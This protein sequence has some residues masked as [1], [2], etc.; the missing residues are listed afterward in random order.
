VTSLYEIKKLEVTDTPVLLFECTLSSGAVERWSTHAVTVDAQSY[1][2]RILRHNLFEI[3]GTGEDGIDSISRVAV[4]LA[5]ADS[6]FSQ[7]ERTVGFKGA[8]VIVRFL[9]Y[10][11]KTGAA[12]SDQRV[13]FR[14]TCNP[15]DEI[16]ES[17]LRLTFMSR[18][19][20]QRTLLPQ[21]RIQRR[22][23]WVFPTTADQRR[24]GIDGLTKGK[25]SPFFRCGYSP[26]IT[27][28]TGNSDT[29]GPFTS[30]D[31]T[32][33]QCEQRGMFSSDSA[34]RITRRFG[35]VE[36]VPSS[37][38]VKTYGD[39]AQYLSTPVENETRYNDFVAMLYGTAW[40]KP[41]IIF[42]RNDGNLTH[43]E[44]LLGM[45]DIHGV[46]KVIANGIEIPAGQAG[47]NM[48]ATGWYNVV[49]LGNRTGNFN[50]D[51]LANG[52]PLGDP[53]GSMAVLSLVLP[54]RISDG[55]TLPRIEVLQQGMKLSTFG[56][57]A[58]YIG[59]EFSNN[60]AWVLLDLLRR[61][62][63]DISEIDLGSFAVT[64]A[65]CAQTIQTQDLHGNTVSIPRFQCNLVVSKRRSAADLIRGIRNGSGLYLC[66]G[67]DGLLQLNAESSIA[68]QQAAKPEG[69]N[70]IEMLNGGWPAYEFGDG[71]SGF[72]DIL[73][74]PHDEPA[75]R[76]TSRS[77]ADTPNRYTVEF[78]DQFNE[79]QQD[80]LSLIDFDDAIT[81]GQE[82]TASLS[83]LGLPN[84]NQTG[85]V[86][87]LQLNRS[88]RGNNYIEF[89][90]GLRSIGVK[91]G[92]L[93]TVTYLKEGLQRQ[94]FRIVRISPGLNYRSS[95]ITAQMHDDA[96]YVSGADGSLGLIGG[97]RQPDYDIGLPRPL[98]G[99]VLDAAGGS[100]FG[101]QETA[102]QSADGTY[103]LGIS[104]SFTAPGMPGATAPGIPLIGLSPQISST[105]G[106]LT[107]GS[108]YYYSV[109]AVDQNGNES[110]TS[111][112]VRAAVGNATNTNQ[113]TLTGLSFAAG[114]SAFHVYRGANPVQMYRI[115]AN[116]PVS[117][118][119]TD[120]GATAILA[121]AP[122]RNYHHANFYWRMELQPE[123]AA[124]IYSVN[125]IGNGT[126]AMIDNEYRSKVARITSG[127]GKGQERTIA[128][129][130]STVL[131]LSS[132]WDVA[133]DSTSHFAAS[134]SAWQFGAVA[135]TSPAAFQIVN[136]D[137]AT[138]QICGR[139]ANVHD[140][141]CA[142]E[143]S[144][145]TRHQI[146]GAGTG[147][148]DTI[149]AGAP[150][151]GLSSSGQG[152]VEVTGIGFEDL[153]NTS[154]ITAASLTLY[155]VDELAAPPSMRLN[156]AV[157]AVSTAL[158]LQSAG[159]LQASD[160][161]QV[162]GEV[163]RV[164]VLPVTGTVF[165]VDRG[166]Y[167]STA[168]AH[169]VNTSAFSLQKKVFIL[170]FVE[171][172]F[173]STASGSYSF[174]ITLP[175]VRIAAADMFVVNDAG[176]SDAG[177]ASFTSTVNAGLRTLSGGQISMQIEGYLAIQNDAVPPI[178]MDATHSIRDVFATVRT[179]PTIYPIQLSVKVDGT[180]YCNLTIA[181]GQTTS[182]VVDGF[183]LGK[184]NANSQFGL[185]IVSV[186]QT[187]D[188]TPGRDLTVTV[189]L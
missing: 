77:T 108:S 103:N 74:G 138:V 188:S 28:G 93:I 51:F 144:P 54:N 92:D 158:D 180:S 29:A 134:E 136:R 147:I 78:Q 39:K 171:G 122:D 4:V 146:T 11:L 40:Y 86:I 124:T 141:E 100:S 9:F 156:S 152:N 151:F 49:S 94:L 102:G 129:N 57:D 30:C 114:T 47:T 33:T 137:H 61:C 31:Y 66:Y 26:D 75:I 71:S 58:G 107:G 27:G 52:V 110:Q 70:S 22:C 162:E 79:Y 21:V 182:N 160:L 186:G 143:L 173:G 135:A 91:P 116:Q 82:I 150:I 159:G 179:A 127:T 101:I 72:S 149:A 5:N 43:L 115:A 42:A 45:G 46:L 23:P 17:E 12:T 132:P 76:L 50:L 128:S 18:L 189:R 87:R 177:Q 133:P 19:S 163:I 89:Q 65:Y 97:G 1:T 117:G 178:S 88:I 130:T 62:G 83:A 24:E 85:R 112:T 84:F 55:S 36:F 168:A 174:P 35:G 154:S 125:T 148:T 64:A 165:Q 16:T 184:V 183:A 187:F 104:V 106:A 25:Y 175:D 126:L 41:L 172:F 10:D 131:T 139:A 63:S 96:W 142:Y 67:L 8:R 90:T 69:S 2:A 157:D 145:V 34:G 37:T 3:R 44:V 99:S 155:F 113:V 153:S 123:F 38:L 53:Y 120:S 118:S 80:S 59:E 15:P 121:G 14:G 98:L 81:A 32:R 13:V 185:D 169:T 170:P 119:F 6:Y 60:P 48:T 161:I 68:V 111:F 166:A 181:V 73:R 167:G 56:T 95:R 105:G 7:L 176:N 20:L 140:R 109:S 164:L